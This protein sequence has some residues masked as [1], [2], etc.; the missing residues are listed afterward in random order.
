[1]ST[2]T[3]YR[4]RHDWFKSTRIVAISRRLDQPLALV[5]M[6]WEAGFNHASKQTDRGSVA[7]FCPEDAGAELGIED[8]AA[9][10]IW[11]AFVARGMIAAGRIAN[12]EE[13][14]PQREDP[15]AAERKRR[16]REREQEVAVDVAQR[17]A[18][19]R[20]DGERES[21]PCSPPRLT[22]VEGKKKGKDGTGAGA[23]TFSPAE[24]SRLVT[25]R[26]IHARV[27]DAART[28]PE[29][30]YAALAEALMAIADPGE[31][32]VRQVL[33]AVPREVRRELETLDREARARRGR[34]KSAA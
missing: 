2:I 29:A 30:R 33:M 26:W 16:Q 19:S 11:A 22:V 17:H 12:W 28:L 8:E 7:H 4:Q 9:A 25:E 3:W 5:A 34:A 31:L 14:E 1:M 23:P 13:L 6:L 15:T 24:R 32:S 27:I 18:S 21:P 10:R 20:Q